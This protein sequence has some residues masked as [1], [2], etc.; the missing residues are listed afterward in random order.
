VAPRR[1]AGKAFLTH[2]SG[3]TG[4]VRAGNFFSF[5]DGQKESGRTAEDLSFPQMSFGELFDPVCKLIEGAVLFLFREASD[6]LIGGLE[7]L[8]NRPI[9]SS[10]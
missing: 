3:T 2:P 8:P 7:C 9:P 1:T 5:I 10:H 4:A 6:V